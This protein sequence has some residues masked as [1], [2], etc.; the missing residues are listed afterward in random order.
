MTTRSTA[1]APMTHLALSFSMW[2]KKLF[3]A[4]VTTPAIIGTVWGQYYA[5]KNNQMALAFC[6]LEVDM[7]LAILLVLGIIKFYEW[8]H[9]K[10]GTHTEND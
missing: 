7:L 8:A 2:K 6:F 9:R 5:I 10:P 1:P 4:V 3:H